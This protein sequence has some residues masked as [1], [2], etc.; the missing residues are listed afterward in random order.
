M[1]FPHSC[2][3]IDV[4]P[5]TAICPPESEALRAKFVCLRTNLARSIGVGHGSRPDPLSTLDSVID[6]YHDHHVFLA[7]ARLS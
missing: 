2:G 5:S 7:G 1:G 6:S 4:H 3:F